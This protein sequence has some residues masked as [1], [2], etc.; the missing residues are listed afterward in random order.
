M[1]MMVVDDD[2]TFRARL[3]AA[4][5]ARNIEANGAGSSDEAIELAARTKPQRAVVDLRMPGGSGLDLVSALLEMDGDVQIVVLTG[6]GS[7]ATA[8]E[9]TRRGAID[10]LTKPADADQILAV[11]EK[12]GRK[13]EV[14]ESVP[15]LARVEWE[16]IHRILTDCGGNISQAARVLRIHRR[17]LQRK[18]NKYPPE[19]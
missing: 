19:P 6:Y 3:V 11:F 13:P 7:I 16:H 15:S 4:L 12:S 14:E 17:S 5:R 1:T 2:A 10:Y 8:L 18:L 9:A